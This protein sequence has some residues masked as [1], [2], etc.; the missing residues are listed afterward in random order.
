MTRYLIDDLY[1]DRISLDTPV[2]TLIGAYVG[3]AGNPSSFIQAD[4]RFPRH[5]IVSIASHNAVDAQILDIENGAVDPG[6]WPTQRAWCIRQFARGV[7]PTIYVNT[8]TWPLID[9]SVRALAN[10]WAANWSGGPNIP[11]GAVGVQYGSVGV[12]DLSIMHDYIEGIDMSQ[13]S[14]AQIEADVAATPITWAGGTQPLNTIL[15][16]LLTIAE[17]NATKLDQITAA[18]AKLTTPGVPPAAPV[19]YAGTINFTAVAPSQRS[20]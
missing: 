10:W 3:H 15:N 14:D 8:S 17:A 4:A 18:V 5:Q 13:P 9:P 16:S 2:T 19:N 1:P 7:H 6:D 12:S 20:T 11:A